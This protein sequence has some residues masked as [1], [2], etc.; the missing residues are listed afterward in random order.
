MVF[1]KSSV[2]YKAIKSK[3][4]GQDKHSIYSHVS[5]LSMRL[6]K[7]NRFANIAVVLKIKKMR[8]VV[9]GLL[10]VW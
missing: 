10:T 7:N 3:T 1:P 4:S 8:Y 9:I 5:D 2:L 6:E